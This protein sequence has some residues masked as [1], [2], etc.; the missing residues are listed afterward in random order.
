[1]NK[2][3]RT[4]LVVGALVLTAGVGAGAAWWMLRPQDG[5]AKAEAAPAIDPQEYR[6]I[7]LEKVIVMLRGRPG[8]SMSHYLA[9]DLVFKTPLKSEKTTK[10][11]LPLLRSVAVMELSRYSQE[12]AAAMTLEEFAANINRAFNDRY[13]R[14]HGEKPF[15]EAM[16]SKLIIE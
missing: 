3:N 14:E 12:K 8:E 5:G 9:M 13:A 15:V 11:H 4:L 16:V 7:N 2:L 10:E 1:M 6:Y